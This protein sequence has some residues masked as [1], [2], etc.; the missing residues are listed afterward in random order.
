VSFSLVDPAGLGD[1]TGIYV[2]PGPDEA[3][4]VAFKFDSQDYGRVIVIESLPDIPDPA[5]RIAAYQ[6]RVGNNGQP[7]YWTTSTIVTLA[8]GDPAIVG[9][10]PSYPA[11]VEWVTKEVQFAVIG[12]TLTGD[13]AVV[14]AN[15]I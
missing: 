9:T 12:P 5:T 10:S 8:T 13:Q 14:I 11:T 6:D 7:G 2:T 15:G 3:A 4:A 1:A